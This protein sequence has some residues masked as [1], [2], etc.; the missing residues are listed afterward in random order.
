MAKSNFWGR[1]IAAISGCND[2]VRYTNFGPF[3]PG[4]PLVE[5]DD[6]DA[7]EDYLKKDP[8]C[9][10]VMLEPVQGE[11]GVR[12]PKTKNY[13]LKVKQLCE[14]YNVLLITDEVQTGLGRTGKLMGWMHDLGDIVRPDICTLGKAISGGITAT[15]GIVAN[16]EIMDVIGP[17][18]HGS[19]YGGNPLSMATAHAAV[20]CLIEEGM[21]ENAAKMGELFANNLRSMN[22]PL[23]KEV[24]N[25]G[26][27]CGMEFHEGLK[28]NAQEYCNLL[29]KQGLVTKATNS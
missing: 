19:T 14:K 12:V 17:G 8:N 21:P 7:I 20:K 16:K 28:L 29:M 5:F 25:R 4:F 15:S 22:H 24:R 9:V 6:V 1:S 11:G 18:E 3:A 10:A 2:P 27:L 26:L 13:L 23:I